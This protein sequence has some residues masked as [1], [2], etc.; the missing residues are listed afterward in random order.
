M[1]RRGKLVGKYAALFLIGGLIYVGMELCWR[2]HSHFT[3]FFLGGIDFILLGLLN[4][5]IPWNMGLLWQALIGSAI[6]TISE[7]ATGCIVNLCFHWNVWDYSNLPL[8]VLGQICLPFSLLWI[9]VATA[10]IVLDD[11]IRYWVFGEEKP[12]YRFI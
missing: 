10:A 1:S 4:E 12:H 5:I 8:N 6:I 9:V 3:M 11:Y 2:G 7:F